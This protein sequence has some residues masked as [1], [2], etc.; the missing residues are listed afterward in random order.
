VKKQLLAAADGMKSRSGR[1]QHI[2]SLGGHTKTVSTD[3]QDAYDS[4][5]QGGIRRDT[6]T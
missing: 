1:T 4:P 3:G 5:N 2:L 6:G